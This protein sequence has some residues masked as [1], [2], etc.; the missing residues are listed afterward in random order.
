MLE[1]VRLALV[2]PQGLIKY[3]KDR[4]IFALLFMAFFAALMT[5]GPLIRIGQFD[6]ISPGARTSIEESFVFP[7][8]DC[9]IVDA[10]LECDEEAR[11]A[12]FEDTLMGLTFSV[13]LDSTD[14]YAP[15]EYEGN[16]VVIHGSTMYIALDELFVEQELQEKPISDMHPS[17]HNLDFNPEPREE[18]AFFNA[19]FNGINQEMMQYRSLWM[20]FSFFTEFF[21][22]MVLF[23]IFVSL[24]A[25]LIRQR[26]SQIPFKQMFVMMTY[27]ST[28]LFVVLVFNNLIMFNFIIFI[29]LLFIG[30]RQTSRL[31]FEIQRRIHN[32]ET[33][34]AQMNARRHSQ[35]DS[36]ESDDSSDDAMDNDTDPK[37]DE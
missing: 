3:R 10:T 27:A 19:L 29:I 17:I 13:Y 20:G 18:S 26:L 11:H 36:N 1:R 16:H 5:V 32:A 2:K 15:A 33:I 12:L 8:Q 25:F 28:L 22:A 37:D 31:A 30:F 34:Q 23:L 4:L 6:S 7:D 14:A 35:T 9:A 21:S 24:N